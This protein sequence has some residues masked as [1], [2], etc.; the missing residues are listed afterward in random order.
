MRR[1]VHNFSI[2]LTT[3]R[4]KQ[5]QIPTPSTCIHHIITLHHTPFHTWSH[6]LY[7]MLDNLSTKQTLPTQTPH[8]KLTHSRTHSLSTQTLH[9]KSH[10]QTHTQPKLCVASHLQNPLIHN[11]HKRIGSGFRGFGFMSCQRKPQNPYTCIVYF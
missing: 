7:S 10:T 11:S 3:G 8:T 1:D 2:K 6:S 9:A 5:Y 4:Q